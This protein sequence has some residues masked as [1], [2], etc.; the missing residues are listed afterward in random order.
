MKTTPMT[1][2]QQT[3]LA[4]GKSADEVARR[5]TG[6]WDL[7]LANGQAVQATACLDDG[8]LLMDAELRRALLEPNEST[9]T[10][11]GRLLELLAWNALLPGGVKFALDVEGGPRL[12]AEIP[13]AADVDVTGRVAQVCEGFRMAC[14]RAHAVGSEPTPLV[15][16]TPASDDGEPCD[17]LDVCRK[18][19]WAVVERA[20]GALTVELDVPEGFYRARIDSRPGAVQVGVALGK[21][22]PASLVCRQAL[23]VLLLSTNGLVRMTRAI[24]DVA[25]DRTPTAVRFEVILA[26]RP[27]V[28]ELAEAFAALSMA[29][30]VCAAE[31]EALENEAVAREYLTIRGWSSRPHGQRLHRDKED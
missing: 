4:L 8:W 16:G 24:V 11:S 17:L 27:A 28:V 9:T 12:R 30:R 6:R 23:G 13:L 2:E 22:L 26:P 25:D 15:E 20:G 14:R 21:D 3:D 10:Q 29:I 19:G 7:A 18:T 1:W 31:A 5:G